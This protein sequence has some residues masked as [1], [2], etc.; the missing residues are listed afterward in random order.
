MGSGY[1][2][3]FIRI[4]DTDEMNEEE[5]EE[6]VDRIFGKFHVQ[7]FFTTLCR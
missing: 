1:H 6:E 4:D 2:D 7:S 3:H 5:N